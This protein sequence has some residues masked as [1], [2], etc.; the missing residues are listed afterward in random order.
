MGG[1]VRFPQAS[2]QAYFF[3]CQKYLHSKYINCHQRAGMSVSRFLMP[4]NIFFFFPYNFF[5]KGVAL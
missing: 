4:E 1:G 5:N 2:M 3:N